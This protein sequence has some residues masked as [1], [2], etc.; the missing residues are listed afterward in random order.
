MISISKARQLRKRI[1]QASASLSDTDALEAIEL[2]PAWEADM[3]IELGKRIR[4]AGKLYR[5][6]QGHTS[7]SVYPP[8]SEGTEALYSEVA[9]PEQGDSP[10]N[11]IPYNN[12]M[13]LFEGKYYSQSGIVYVCFRATGIPVYNDLTDLVGIYVNVWAAA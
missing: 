8:G 4:Y 10:D 3:W 13:E 6:E 11:P 12:N 2:F 9:K 7:S 5:C 1:E